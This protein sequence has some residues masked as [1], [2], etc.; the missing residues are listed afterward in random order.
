MTVST[1]LTST[2]WSGAVITAA[3]GQSFSSVSAEWVVPTVSQVPGQTTTDASEWVGLDGYKSNDVCQ[4][5]I[6]QTVQTSAKGKTTITTYAWDEWYPA[7]SNQIA[8][9]QVNPG[10]T[11]KITVDTLGAGSSKASFIF[12]DV[13]TGKTVDASLTAPKGTTL[14]GNSAEAVVETPEFI[15]GNKVSQ[16]LLADFVST[17]VTFQDFS[18]LYSGGTGASLSSALSIGMVSDEVPGSIGTYVQEAY[19]SINAG[20][21]SVTVTE[22]DYWPSG[23]SN[24]RF[25]SEGSPGF[26]LWS[27]G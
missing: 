16:P 21:D 2:N 11:V 22:D 1:S 9:F 26:S 5:G 27:D 6:Q 10:D 15:S 17:P 25:L 18:A 23:S 13:T 3:S 14:V 7:G 12:Q 20:S 8:G 19:G 24:S 4:A